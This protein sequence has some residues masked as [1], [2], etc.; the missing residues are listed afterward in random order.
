M[1]AFPV[2][3]YMRWREYLYIVRMLWI[4]RGW[5]LQWTGRAAAARQQLLPQFIP[6]GRPVL[7]AFAYF[8]ITSAT[9][10]DAGAI[11]RRTYPGEMLY[12]LY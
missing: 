9:Q 1:T 2:S 4:P 3:V 12:V 7:S 8:L 5:S 11:P 6:Q 10:S